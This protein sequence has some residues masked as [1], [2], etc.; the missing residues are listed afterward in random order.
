MKTNRTNYV[1]LRLTEREFDILKKLAEEDIE[2]KTLDGKVNLSAYIR[3]VVFVNG[4]PKD[5]K[6]EL[7]NLNFQIRKIGVNINQVVKRINSGYFFQDDALHLAEELKKIE[8][9]ENKMLALLEEGI[10]W[11]SQS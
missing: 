9:L 4:R 1:H 10:L 2:S 5:M 7:R 6:R 11:Q 3:N 8:E